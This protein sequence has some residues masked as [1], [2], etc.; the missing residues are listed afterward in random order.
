MFAIF[1]LAILN[2]KSFDVQP[3]KYFTVPDLVF[4]L[5]T[6]TMETGRTH[7]T[8]VRVKNLRFLL[9]L[10]K[11]SIFLLPFSPIIFHQLVPLAHFT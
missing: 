11:K 5:T 6:Q 7:I 8:E 1:I 2:Y 3:N 10:M 9:V 4:C